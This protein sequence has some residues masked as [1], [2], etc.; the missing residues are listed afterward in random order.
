MHTESAT[1]YYSEHEG[2]RFK[3]DIIVRS[4]AVVAF[5]GLMVWIE[6]MTDIVDVPTTAIV[7]TFTSVLI[8]WGAWKQRRVDRPLGVGMDE[9]A[10]FLDVSFMQRGKTI[11]TVPFTDIRAIRRPVRSTD[12]LTI[13]IRDRVDKFAKRTITIDAS[14]PGID[15]LIERL[16]AQPFIEVS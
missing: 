4:A 11:R 8:F 13:V 9:R 5:Y 3:R 7:P 10:L 16:S 6:A 14:V 15:G 2:K 12:P 1:W